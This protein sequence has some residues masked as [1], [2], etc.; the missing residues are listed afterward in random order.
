[1]KIEKQVCN[2][3]LA[4]RLKQLNCKQESLFYWA[5]KSRCLN[6]YYFDSGETDEYILALNEYKTEN[7]KKD[8]SAFTVAELGEMLLQFPYP[9]AIVAK[10][11]SSGVFVDIQFR[12]GFKTVPKLNMTK[13][14]IKR[15]VNKY[16]VKTL[17]NLPKTEADA[18]AKLLIYLIENK[19]IKM[20]EPC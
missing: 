7:S 16:G 5:N 17:E 18:R 15:K 3:K 12:L 1:M 20:K 6:G 8:Y 2:L 13:M 19:I 14:A 10:W 9:A 4:K 11:Y